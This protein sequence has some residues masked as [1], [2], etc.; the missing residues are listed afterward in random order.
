MDDT[1]ALLISCASTVEAHLRLPQRHLLGWPLARSDLGLGP[2]GWCTLTRPV[3]P[4][5]A[6]VAARRIAGDGAASGGRIPD[7][8]ILRGERRQGHRG[9]HDP[10]KMMELDIEEGGSV[11]IK[12]GQIIPTDD[13]N[14]PSASIRPPPSCSTMPRQLCERGSLSMNRRSRLRR[15]KIWPGAY[16]SRS[17]ASWPMHNTHVDALLARSRHQAQHVDV[18]ARGMAMAERISRYTS[19]VRFFPAIVHGHGR[20]PGEISVSRLR[21]SR[22]HATPA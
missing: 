18:V 1:S 16:W 6:S 14:T 4:C 22:L 21:M 13:T 15:Q 3:T 7:V 11:S 17:Q 2:L 9:I 8:L 5:P 12:A 10:A 19:F 20:Q